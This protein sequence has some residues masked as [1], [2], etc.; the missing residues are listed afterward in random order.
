MAFPLLAVLGAVTI[1]ATALAWLYDQGTE[2]EQERHRNLEEE[3]ARLSEEFAR[4][5]NEQQRGVPSR[6]LVYSQKWIELLEAE[7]AQLAQKVAPIASELDRVFP[8]ILSEAKNPATDTFRRNMLKRELLRFDDAKRKL[9]AYLLYTEWF[10][11]RL[12]QISSSSS[13]GDLLSLSPPSVTLP[14]FWLYP[15]KLVMLPI[16]MLGKELPEFGH[17]ILLHR[18]PSRQLQQ[19]YFTPPGQ[20]ASPI[21]IDRQNRDRP[22]V[23]W[24]C[25]LKGAFFLKH[26]LGSEPASF[27]I[28]RGGDAYY[29]GSMLE[30]QI[31]AIL[32]RDNMFSAGL[33][34][35]EGDILN[36]YPEEFD[37]LLQ[38]NYTGRF[39]LNGK[40]TPIVSE[41][42]DYSTS[43]SQLMPL[44]L[45]LESSQY[46]ESICQILDD[47]SEP[48][49]LLGAMVNEENDNLT[50]MLS[51]G[52]VA[53]SCRV[54]P[55]GWL[56]MEGIASDN[57]SFGAGIDLPILI[58]PAEKERKLAL[59]PCPDG[60]FL[61]DRFIERLGSLGKRQQSAL[62][63]SSFFDNWMQALAFLQKEEGEQELEFPVTISPS[64]EHG[65]FLLPLSS[66]AEDP[67][68]HI[69]NFWESFDQEC[70][71][72]PQ[73]RLTLSAWHTRSDGDGYWKRL[74]TDSI[75]RSADNYT[76]M[77]RPHPKAIEDFLV[78]T[79]CL[80]KLS[81]RTMQ[82]VPLERQKNALVA[83]RDDRL[84]N[85]E[86]RDAL[87]LPDESFY[88]PA[89]SELWKE[90]L[91]DEAIWSPVPNELSANQKDVVRTCLSV[92]PLV[93]VQGPPGTGK[94]RCILEIVYQY[95]S[96]N[97]TGRVLISSQQNT[98]VDNV[99]ERLV[100][101]HQNFLKANSISIMRI[102]N[103][104]KM[105]SES[106]QFTFNEH[107]KSFTNTL[108]AKAEGDTAINSLS[109][110]KLF[111][112]FLGKADSDSE[113]QQESA[114]VAPLRE[115]LKNFLLP[116]ISRSGI[117]NEMLFCMTT[118][119][120]IVAATCVG[121]ANK[122]AAMDQCRFD[123]VIIDEAGRATPPEL[124]IP[125]KLAKKVVLIGDHYQLPPSVN[126]LL[127]EESTQEVLPF[128]KETFLDSSFFGTLFDALPETARCRLTEQY[129]MDNSIG[130]LVADLFYTENGDRRLYNGASEIKSSGT[131]K[132]IDVKGK[133]ERVGTSLYN[134]HEAQKALNLLEFINKSAKQSGFKSVAMITPYREQKKLLKKICSQAS[135]NNLQSVNINTIDQFQGSEA[136]VVIYSTVRNYGPIDFLLDQKRLNVA[137]SRARHALFFIG[138]KDV[139]SEK[140]SNGPENFFSKILERTEQASIK[141]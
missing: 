25:A 92:E 4:Y 93:V 99:I 1:S 40:T 6:A 53:I 67:Q 80:F 87:L 108:S 83:M 38:G 107:L 84:A 137:C 50:V 54:D 48:F 73:K 29:Q 131:I 126:P 62:A 19:M 96:Y 76:L 134:E 139:F 70:D 85:S 64:N 35:R 10:K 22:G 78:G 47:A 8:L 41:I 37:L 26:V 105:S 100:K 68:G 49:Y 32:P 24:G 130:D 34:R 114:S 106:Q 66:S 58:I 98:A 121:L 52:G 45:L 104:G 72:N 102:G 116:K 39:E 88:K 120:Q 30:G 95:L 20:E 136:D 111:S 2:R 135:F 56:E 33:N 18:W 11:T 82:Y 141:N 63:A 17:S 86:L 122:A 79:V 117:D 77:V 23:F 69:E 36:V 113:N 112:R 55:Q 14:E 5:K 57:E 42:P 123:L 103:E 59:S 138:N 7:L 118:G 44:F 90:R 28:S 91:E 124:L 75:E 16:D 128:L 129:R 115:R 9:D 81:F 89:S 13:S 51:K 46:E 60:L 140:K 132:W 15:G 125:M 12:S 61:L 127:R 27:R 31:R 109:L 119:C 133:H 43:A 71:F 21:L 74:Y 97:P 101:H 65:E 3:F 110:P 94:T